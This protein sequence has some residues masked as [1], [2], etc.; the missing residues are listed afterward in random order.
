MARVQMGD[1]DGA[2]EDGEAALAVKAGYQ[3]A[4][5]LMQLVSYK[6]KAATHAP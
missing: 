2:E 5:A 4:M 3:P 1:L 6:R